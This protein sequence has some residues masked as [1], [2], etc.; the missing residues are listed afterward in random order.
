MSTIST[1]LWNLSIKKIHLSVDPNGVE[2]GRRRFR[3]D[4]AGFGG[5]TP[6][7][8]RIPRFINTRSIRHI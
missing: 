3:P 7:D 1:T 8:F 4:G 5:E 6:S 2:V